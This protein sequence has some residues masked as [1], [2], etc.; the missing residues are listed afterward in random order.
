MSFRWYFMMNW[1][2]FESNWCVFFINT[3]GKWKLSDLDSKHVR[4]DVKITFFYPAGTA[5]FKCREGGVSASVLRVV[6]WRL[7]L[8]SV[9]HLNSLQRNEILH[10]LFTIQKNCFYSDFGSRLSCSI[11]VLLVVDYKNNTMLRKIWQ[12]KRA[13]RQS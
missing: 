13:I 3:F 1:K 5:I 6:T 9:S 2:S 8:V 4:Y 7:V 12:H 11:R 10:E